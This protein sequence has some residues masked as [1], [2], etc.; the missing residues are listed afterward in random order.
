MSKLDS[1]KVK[2][3]IH[4]KRLEVLRRKLKEKG[5]DA[6][7]I[8]KR[9]NYL[10]MSGFTGTSACLVIT[11]S[12]AF[13]ITDFRYTEQAT[14]QAPLYEVVRYKD[15]LTETINSVLEGK[16]V[17]VL[18]FEDTY[19]TYDKYV[20]YKSGLNVK[21]FMPLGKT[22]ESMRMVKDAEE[23]ENIEK[24]VKIADEAFRHIL[25]FI[26]PGVKEI[27]LAAELEYFMK[28]KG[29]TGPSF[30]TII[31]SGYRSSM[32]HGTAS[33]K[34]IEL[35]DPITFDFGAIYNNYCSDMTRT[36]FV[37]Q[38]DETMK[39]IYNIVLKAQQRACEG[40]VAG[41]TGKEIDKI[42]RDIISEAGYGENF[43]H[44]LGHGVGLEIHEDPRLSVSGE[45][46]M[47]DGMVV[48]VEPGIYLPGVGG[49]RIEDVVVINKDKPRILTES[50]K[51][52][53][54]L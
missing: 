27:E 10:Y 7:L 48:T 30:E 54:V 53:I 16:G 45:V 20:Q 3:G 26:K 23:T 43:G 31:A 25:N 13:L 49:V 35:G 39:N 51:E 24:A 4:A 40:A 47:E 32:P 6:A 2:T 18:G 46:T 22:L 41:L 12:K 11:D 34:K 37:G 50:P 33:E 1:E 15:S 38:P 42:A 9:E 14:A 52:L 21:E 5:L 8:T 36:V 19:L 29:V 28:K 44:G 17:N